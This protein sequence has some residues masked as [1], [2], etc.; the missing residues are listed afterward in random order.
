MDIETE[1]LMVENSNAEKSSTLV[2]IED[3]CDHLDVAL[4]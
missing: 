3:K 1:K 4:Q 2:S